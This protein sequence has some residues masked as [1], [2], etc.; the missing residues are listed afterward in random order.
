MLFLLMVTDLYYKTYCYLN[1][2]YWGTTAWMIRK[3]SANSVPSYAIT[4]NSAKSLIYF[5]EINAVGFL[6]FIINK[7]IKDCVAQSIQQV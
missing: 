4:V 5:S 1:Y 7:T 3:C 2:D 6:L